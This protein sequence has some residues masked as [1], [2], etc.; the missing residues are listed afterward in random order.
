MRG[1]AY[2][3]IWCKFVLYKN[4]ISK[5]LRW[6][7]LPAVSHHRRLDSDTDH[8]DY[9]DQ[10]KI[11]DDLE[12]FN[13]DIWKVWDITQNR[14]N[15]A[16]MGC[17]LDDGSVAIKIH[18]SLSVSHDKVLHY[19]KESNLYYKWIIG[20]ESSK[21]VFQI[22]PVGTIAQ[23]KMRSNLFKFIPKR[24]SLNL[25]ISN[26]RGNKDDEYTYFKSIDMDGSKAK[27]KPLDLFMMIQTVSFR[28]EQITYIDAKILI[29]PQKGYLKEYLAK[30]LALDLGNS[31][32]N[33][34]SFVIEKIFIKDSHITT[35]SKSILHQIE[36]IRKEYVESNKPHETK[37]ESE[38]NKNIARS[39]AVES[40]A[41]SSVTK[42]ISESG[43]KS[44][45]KKIVEIIEE[46]IE[47]DD[48]P[49]PETTPYFSSSKPKRTD[50]RIESVKDL[51]IEEKK[52]LSAKSTIKDEEDESW[53]EL[54]YQDGIWHK[55][56]I[57][58]CTDEEKKIYFKTKQ[59]LEENNMFFGENA[60]LK[61]LAA[62]NFDEEIAYECLV[63]NHTYYKDN[64]VEVLIE[65]EFQK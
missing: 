16:I 49:I 5:P 53:R 40:S 20:W 29:K 17:E 21:E 9:E 52:A 61:F 24:Y 15:I 48:G 10:K 39:S 59:R 56:I 43:K 23:V 55:W 33:L 51:E 62:K 44:K 37:L 7:S 3:K 50:S 1:Y 42:Q 45:H 13:G 63:K 8:L 22:S 6:Q 54:C 46:I 36:L 38:S 25:F 11:F 19:L 28:E 27:S 14:K 4:W 64:N 26:R 35:K 57:E 32:S 60:I 30:Q 2:N 31:I 58:R 41:K 65:S 18:S 12:Q 47:L 34:E